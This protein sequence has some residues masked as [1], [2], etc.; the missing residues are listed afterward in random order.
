MAVYYKQR[1]HSPDENSP[2]AAGS[3]FRGTIDGESI[4]FRLTY[5]AL[6]GAVNTALI[7]FGSGG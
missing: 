5:S 6:E 2:A 7:H 3:E 1:D 4:C